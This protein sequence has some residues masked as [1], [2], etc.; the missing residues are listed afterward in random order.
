MTATNKTSNFP[1][2]ACLLRVAVGI[3]VFATASLMGAGCT[4]NMFR[5]SLLTRKEED[6]PPTWSKCPSRLLVMVAL[7]VHATRFILYRF[8]L[9]LL[10]LAHLV[11][12]RTLVECPSLAGRFI[13]GTTAALSKQNTRIM[14]HR[15]PR[16]SRHPLRNIKTHMTKPLPPNEISPP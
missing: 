10:H 6:R 13:V 8:F 16:V 9:L 1:L 15:L 5:C 2:A 12:Y 14:L 11:K 7:I 3:I 4:S